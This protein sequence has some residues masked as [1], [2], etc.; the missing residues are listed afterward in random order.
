MAFCWGRGYRAGSTSLRRLR[1]SGQDAWD[2][3][4]CSA[5]DEWDRRLIGVA[6]GLG[7]SRGTIGISNPPPTLGCELAHSLL[8]GPCQVLTICAQTLQTG[9]SGSPRSCP[10]PSPDLGPAS[11]APN[12]PLSLYHSLPL[13]LFSASLV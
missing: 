2:G 6:W 7:F 4:G 11:L 5:P 8:A 3:G 9:A 1:R 13:F 10:L 12:P